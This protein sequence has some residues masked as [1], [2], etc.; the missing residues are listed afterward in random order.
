MNRGR[1]ALI[2]GDTDAARDAAD[3]VI[4][5]LVITYSQATIRYATLV[6]A[7][8][9]NSDL[10][11]AAEHRAEGLAFFRV[12]EAIV[13]DAGAD[14]DAINAIYDLEV[15]LGSTGGDDIGA[16]L[17]PAWDNLGISAEDIG[18]LDS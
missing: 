17:Q 8:V 5:N 15:E 7:D 10:D 18:A 13:A 2:A 3:D 4:R 12:I 16:A 1:D 11:A 14:V 6:P 9:T